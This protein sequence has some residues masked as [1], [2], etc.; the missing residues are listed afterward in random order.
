M[1][2]FGIAKAVH[3]PLTDQSVYTNVSQMVGTP[4]YMSPEQAQRSGLDIDTRTDVYSLGVLLYEL[5][6]GTTPFEKDRLQNSSLDEV[7]RI[8]REE[9]PPRPSTRLSTLNA[10]QET[11]AERHSTDLRAISHEL[12]GELDWIVMKALEKD[13]NRRYESASDF[14]KDLQRHLDDEPVEA[15]PPSKVYRFGKFARRNRTGLVTT[16]LVVLALVVG[17]GVALWQA[18]RANAQAALA[19]QA[20]SQAEAESE[21]ARDNLVTALDA[22]DEFSTQIVESYLAVLPHSESI[23]REIQQKAIRFY[24]MFTV[25]NE[26]DPTLRRET[27]K[28]YH[29][30]GR[31]RWQSNEFS[32]A[33]L[34]YRKCITVLRDLDTEAPSP[35]EDYLFD[36]AIG[37]ADLGLV[38]WRVGRITEAEQV[39]PD[40]IIT[41]ERLVREFP[42]NP[43]YQWALADTEARLALCH[44]TSHQ[45][46]KF[47]YWARKSLAQVT[48]DRQTSTR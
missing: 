27:A 36:L 32:S 37:E 3:Q 9:D 21:R 16:A 43:G 6:T 30:L 39:L 20:T 29:R 23:K 14:A 46:T 11:V 7:K 40:A 15:C 12:S 44:C 48:S 33:I 47:E 22:V 2:D 24:Q 34:A 19:A 31:L 38:L 28:A 26:H 41:L 42:E 10:A 13:R 25:K 45:S 17:T 4:L 35:R 8:I 5:L 18:I 1:I